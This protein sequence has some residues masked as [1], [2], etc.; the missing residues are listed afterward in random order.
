VAQPDGLI[1]DRYETLDVLGRGGQGEVYKAL[2]HQHGRV[3]ALKVRPVPDGEQRHALLAEARIL[4]SLRPHPNLPLVREDFF[5][6]DR[7]ALVMD[8]VE[9]TD[10]GAVLLD[11]GDPGLPV[12]SVLSWLSQSADAVDHL[13]SQGVIHGDVKPANLVLTP[14]GRIVLVDFGISRRPDETGLHPL[15]SPGYAAPE[16]L[17]G[18]LDGAADVYGLAAT[19]VALLTGSPPTGG[20]PDWEGVPNAGAIE[21][22]IRRGLAIDPTRRPRSATELVERLRAHLSLDL[23]TGVVTFLLTDIEGSTARWEDDPDAMSDLIALHDGLI[24]DAIETS[25]GRLLKTRGEGDSTFSV[26]TRAS[27]AAT[28]ALA[29]LRMLIERTG[30]SVRV[31]IHSGEA[32]TRDGDY[33]G[34]TVNR[35]SRLRSVARGGQVLLS[36]AAADLVVDA[37]PDGA[38]L[39]DLG[40]HELRDLARGEQV[41]AITHPAL[42]A[43]DVP[44]EMDI[45]PP[46]NPPPNNVREART[47]RVE[48]ATTFDSSPP[49]EAG[50]IDAP[51]TPPVATVPP[52]PRQ[53]VATP[54]PLAGSRGVRLPLPP[55]LTTAR[56][57]TFVGRQPE[58]DRLLEGWRRTG[59]GERRLVLLAG[60]PGIGKTQLAIELAAAAHA[61]GALVLHGR[62]DDGLQVPYQPFAAALGQVLDDAQAAGT[63]PPLG[64][65]A[66]ELVRLAPEIAA[67]V[68]DLPPPLRADPE[69]EQYRLFDA[70][71]LWLQA[72]AESSP[73]MLVLDD[74]HWATRP[75]L[76]LLRHVLRTSEPTPLF[77]LGTYR[78]TELGRGHA[79]S[80]LLADLHR[81]PG[82]DRL[83]IDGLDEDEVVALLNAGAGHDFGLAGRSLA[84]TI[85]ALTDGNPF[86]VRELLR[87]MIESGT[88][89]PDADGEW[90]ILPTAGPMGV[91][92][93]VREVVGRRLGRLSDAASATLGLAAVIGSD[94]D[95]DVLV[96][97]GALDEEDVLTALDEAVAARLVLE[98][99]PL[100][101]RFA[102]NI[103]RAT[104]TEGLTRAR[105]SR[106]HRRVA[107]AIE[108]RYSTD[109][110]G[111]LTELAMH[112]A[113]AA[114]AGDGTKAVEYATRA[115]DLATAR[116]AHEEAVDCYRLA[117]ELLVTTA[118]PVDEQSR[119]RLLIAL[120]EAER[121]AGDPAARTTLLEAGRV[122]QRWRDG[123][124]LARAALSNARTSFIAADDMDPERVEM[125]DAAL[126]L[127]PDADSTVRARLLAHLG[128]ER[129]LG[130]GGDEGMRSS[131][132][133]LAIARRLDDHAVLAEVLVLRS[134]T[135]VDPSAGKERLALADQQLAL[136][137]ELGDPALE[138]QAA[139][140]G[141]V[142][143]IE[144][145][146]VELADARLE[147][148]RHL[149]EELGQ[150]AFRWQVLI[151]DARLA[152]IA[153]RFEEAEHN[154]NAALSV[155]QA[156]GHPEAVAVYTAQLYTIRW[157]QGRLE[158]IAGLVRQFFGDEP[159]QP[160]AR[161]SV[162]QTLVSQGRLE[163]ARRWFEP[164]LDG[165]DPPFPATFARNATWLASIAMVAE[166]CA[167]LGDANRAAR[168]IEVLLPHRDAYVGDHIAWGGA[169]SEYLGRLYTTVGRWDD[170]ELALHD[171]VAANERVAA[172]AKAA[173]S[174]IDLGE[175][176]LQRKRPGD[177]EHGISLLHDALTTVERLGMRAHGD[178]IRRLLDQPADDPLIPRVAEPEAEPGA[179]PAA[180]QLFAGRAD[181]L[182]RLA[183]AWEEAR[184]GSSRVVQVAG[185]PGVGKTRVLE[186]LA[187]IAT[188]SGAIVLRGHSDD[189]SGGPFQPFIEALRAVLHATDDAD[190]PRVLGR[191][192][193]ELTRL[194]PEVAE[195]LPVPP[196]SIRSDPET[197]RYRLFDAVV[198]WLR[199][200][201]ADRPVLLLLDD[202]QNAGRPTMQLVRHVARALHD[203][204]G[205]VVVAYR[206][207]EIGRGHPLREVLVDLNREPGTERVSLGPLAVDDVAAIVASRLDRPASSDLR[208]FTLA[209][210]GACGGNPF[211][212]AELVDHLVE[213]GAVGRDEPPSADVLGSAGVPAGV[214]AVVRRRLAR[215]D[216]I[217]VDVLQT[218]ALVGESFD[219]TVLAT[220]VDIDEDTLFTALDKATEAGIL[221]EEPGL[222]A[223]YRFTQSLIRAALADDLGELT[224][225]AL[226]ERIGL[227]IEE[228]Y[229]GRL[230]DHVAELA[231]HFARS[232]T[233]ATR[234]VDY[235]MR[236]G[237][238]ALEQLA[239]DVAVSSYEQALAMLGA[240]DASSVRR[241][242][243]L[244]RLGEAQRRSADTSYRGT[245]F[246][247]ASI[248]R[249]T[250]DTDLLV[251][252]ALA[253]YRASFSSLGT[254]D[255]DRIT[256]LEEAIAAV[257]EDDSSQRAKLLA[258]LA[259]ELMFGGDFDRRMALSTEALSTARRLD[260]PATLAQVIGARVEAIGHAS[261]IDERRRLLG[262]QAELASRLGDPDLAI[263]SSLQRYYVLLSDG[264]VE[265]ASLVLQ[266]ALDSA[267]ASSQPTL[268]WVASACRA[269]RAFVAGRF[270][271]TEALLNEAAHL[272]QAANQPDVWIV[273]V[274]QLGLVRFFQG[275]LDELAG[276]ID[277]AANAAPGVPA[278]A[279]AR[280]TLL[281]ELGR[282]EDARRVFEEL[283]ADDF[284][285]FP[286]DLVWLSGMALSA[287]VCYRL[288]DRERARVLLERLAPYG[289]R[290]IAEGPNFL[291]SVHRFLA[292]M[293]SELER[294]DE[295]DRWFAAALD[296]H[297]RLGAR[298]FAAL[299][300]VDWAAML[301]TRGERA[302]RERA[303]SLLDVAM[304]DSEALGMRAAFD[305]ARGL[306]E[307][308]SRP[309]LP[310]GLSALPRTFIGRGEELAR[311]RELWHKADSGTRQLALIAGESG[312]GK[313]S[314]AAEQARNAYDEGALV[315]FGR[316]DED[317][318]VPLQ[319]FVEIVRELVA[320]GAVKP[321]ELGPDVARLLPELDA[322][323]GDTAGGGDP[324]SER[325]R[326]LDALAAVLDQVA[327]ERTITL[328]LDDL[329]WA[330]QPT[331]LAVRHLVRRPTQVGL[332]V[333]GTY[334]DTEVSRAHPLADV[335]AELRRE[336]L[337]E[338]LVLRGLSTEEVVALVERRAGYALDEED[339]EFAV[340]LRTV[341]EGNP[342]FIGEI[343]Q[344]LV[345]TGGLVRDESGRWNT[346]ARSWDELAVPEGVRD[347][348][349]RRLSRLSRAGEQLLASAAVLGRSFSYEVVRRMVEASDEDVLAALDEALALHLLVEADAS[350]SPGYAFSHALVRETLYDELS[351]PRR[352]R[353]HVRAAD[354]IE[355]AYPAEQLDAFVGALA[356][357]HR[358]AGAAADP[359]RAVEWSERAGAAAFRVFAYEEA[360][361][362]FEG[363]AAI[364]TELGGRENDLRRARLLQRL[365]KLRFF[366]GSDPHEGVRHGEEALVI[367]ERYGERQRAAGIHSQLGAHLA[368]AGTERGLDV[369]RGLR[370]LEAAAP[371]LASGSDRRAGY[372][373]VSMAN[374]TIRALRLADVEAASTRAIEIADG[375]GDRS[376]WANASL[377]RGLGL[378][379]RG[380]LE[381]GGALIEQAHAAAEELVNPALILLTTWNRG[382]QLLVLDDPITAEAWFAR[383]LA[384]PRFADAP[385]AA[386]ALRQNH[387]RCLFELGRLGEL[388]PRWTGGWATAIADRLG[389][390][391]EAA[392]GALLGLLVEQRAMG[393]RWTQLWHSSMVAAA[394]RQLGDVE[395]S[396]EVI[397]EGLVLALEGGAVPQQVALRCEQVL[398]DPAAGAAPLAAALEIV[399]SRT[400]W[401]GIPA[402]L[403]HAAAAVRAANGDHD[404]AD[405]QFTRAIAGYRSAGRPWAEADVLTT[406]ARATGVAERR[407]EAAA[408]YNR[409]GAAPHWSERLAEGGWGPSR[410]DS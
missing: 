125:L 238:R 164:V 34:R 100:R 198:G 212:V 61:D 78:D 400:G 356:V 18:Q 176:Y 366:T 95:L 206:D 260:D 117:C 25:G 98:S 381:E 251:R 334:R 2:D 186:E 86:F 73:V 266:R 234:A 326:L 304:M 219:L 285:A 93:G 377:L 295:A 274:G 48:P 183:R 195:R 325:Y 102:H 16:L 194:V 190:V 230:D 401:R 167:E 142:A 322:P 388:D 247:A 282:T 3:V 391:V 107:E 157:S 27:D 320:V 144:D 69:T 361:G 300:R 39:V 218:A 321:S 360:A 396:S 370:H 223:R 116:L 111:H 104:I 267:D 365:L 41:F 292:L 106:A 54:S 313:T 371:V 330:D 209:V 187:S 245:L 288:H 383:E 71:S 213:S 235:L 315:L 19:A 14:E 386:A 409:I 271:E 352:Q 376:L 57:A 38:G 91:P 232:G 82:M 119:C 105:R 152:M 374:A 290:C 79:L 286:Q 126:Q 160:I 241:G 308:L 193:S 242:E 296:T 30:L 92:E 65:L 179:E 384:G 254:V 43:F 270:D 283:A 338:R 136:A 273:Y 40:F 226:H 64:R 201:A 355:S 402:R 335:L 368:T 333:V 345:E 143:A 306:L 405:E 49:A 97:A 323:V 240:D 216:P 257:G 312:I 307:A 284:G 293:A 11:T 96:A 50:P 357:H 153:G 66:G 215:L 147:R 168:I 94:F 53:P 324:G 32:E 24:A 275:R 397:V 134:A 59:T 256:L 406:W 154:A 51:T 75:T 408:V 33:F 350:S 237:D 329:H 36:A 189:G 115:G 407:A 180:A 149:A 294:F 151:Q 6:E 276:T 118:A 367:Y 268:R 243:V 389:G 398:L 353:L 327:G 175:L 58:L 392:T 339:Q 169:V 166:V 35:A 208:P 191:L 202:L 279:A 220:I 113:E 185:E 375:L 225:A 331:L 177:R 379:E 346:A 362:H 148:A 310:A 7:Y 231:N 156:A 37:L 89:A 9:G 70:V 302:D 170:A 303:R 128:A 159:E 12:S 349:G 131:D 337:F 52:D 99:G 378:F 239:D 263:H 252:A 289:G 336:R 261:T 182:A 42:P 354:A 343:L 10:L 110:D 197:E 133:A 171:A 101:F 196:P 228:A 23:P 249:Q 163:E 319:P 81:L 165:T 13:H 121:I 269:T 380:Q 317:A 246:E 253:N 318:V 28:A 46:P 272:G 5:W 139:I 348:I 67:L 373:H 277:A 316:C 217:T 114:T 340:A 44:R 146:D 287:Q 103:V 129:A 332:F 4:L 347:V 204:R 262:E 161:I 181:E 84:H 311:L 120:G 77:V 301:L 393:D 172:A 248:A 63:P 141:T 207:T 112:Y 250:G 135:L 192:G 184:A 158:E 155:G 62:C 351:L 17:S 236:S 403:E 291:G 20:R 127:I 68:P 47:M 74:L 305:E 259:V 132:Q 359:A 109:L 342:F 178:R 76:H 137:A 60:E 29:L 85:H 145:G 222:R 88:I 299:T 264:Q 404:G 369:A 382:Y 72:M 358:Q 140:N 281:V 174:R 314:L 31:A 21:R 372:F 188:M 394:L 1:R 221:R 56:T 205:L 80:E 227:A 280:A 210:H 395:R 298:G 229:A 123:D 328:V 410:A 224:A 341:A 22:A 255:A 385:R 122:A 203:A 278:L 130:S 390:D 124:L 199:A 26:F 45:S 399:S 162:A 344:H 150:P 108:Q 258:Q 244:V 297:E 364:L 309:P 214:R 265:E 90:A 8:W 211:F 200:T 173:H 15:G 387:R 83:V 87:H 233:D 363:A 55:T 138:V